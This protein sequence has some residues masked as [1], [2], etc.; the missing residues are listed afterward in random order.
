MS[1]QVH[2]EFVV[3]IAQWHIRKMILELDE[4][5]YSA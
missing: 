5:L 1:P 3:N 4:F 2:N